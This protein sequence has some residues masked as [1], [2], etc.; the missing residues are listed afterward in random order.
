VEKRVAE[1]T[2]KRNAARVITMQEKGEKEQSETKKKVE[3]KANAAKEIVQKKTGEAAAKAAA[4]KK[5]KLESVAKIHAESHVK[6]YAKSTG[7]VELAARIKDIERKNI[8]LEDRRHEMQRKEQIDKTEFKQFVAQQMEEIREQR[9]V[10][11]D[12]RK[13]RSRG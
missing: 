4:E 13:K 12:M 11:N 5:Y 6:Q 1:K 10:A 3:C 9:S 7:A 2:K 8:D